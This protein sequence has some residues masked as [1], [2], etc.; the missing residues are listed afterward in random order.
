MPVA[1]FN[2]DRIS[3]ALRPRRATHRVDRRRPVD[4]SG[5]GDRIDPRRRPSCTPRR[6]RVPLSIPSATRY[7]PAH[8]Q[9]GPIDGPRLR[10]ETRGEHLLRS[11]RT[12]P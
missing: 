3:S 7:H 6:R 10:S 1:V 2:L 5:L 11:N 4:R 12:G 8:R 9:G